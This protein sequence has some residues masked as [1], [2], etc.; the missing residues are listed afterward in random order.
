[1]A[2]WA[3]DLTNFARIKFASREFDSDNGLKFF[4][5]K[6]YFPIITYSHVVYNIIQMSCT[7]YNTVLQFIFKKHTQMFINASNVLASLDLVLLLLS[8]KQSRMVFFSRKSLI[9]QTL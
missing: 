3:G 7:I 8:I 4:S 1:M 6:Q 2:E 5:L 9:D